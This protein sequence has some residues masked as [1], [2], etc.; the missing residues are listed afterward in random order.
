[1]ISLLVD[2]TSPLT[3]IQV[4]ANVGHSEA[5]SGNTSIIKA[6]LALEKRIIPPN[7]NFETPNP[8]SKCTSSLI[9]HV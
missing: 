1:V 2:H 4:K 7:V 9:K 3:Y 6:I 5:A 8:R